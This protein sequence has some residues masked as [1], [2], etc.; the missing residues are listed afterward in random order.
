MSRF[1]RW[2]RRKLGLDETPSMSAAEP[3]TEQTEEMATEGDQT[4]NM[5]VPDTDEE[6]QTPLPIEEGSLDDQLPDPDTLGPGSD[7]KAFMAPG[8]SVGL[9][10]RALRRLFAIGNYNVRDGLDDY[11]H[12]YSQMKTLAEGAS[13][14]IRQWT[15]RAADALEED[16]EGTQQTQDSELEPTQE[17]AQTSPEP[18]EDESESG[19]EPIS[20]GAKRV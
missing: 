9:R 1:E 12:D 14:T 6:P 19:I 8:V 16:T 15:K 13:E 10:R 17:I 20:D 5:I 7:F 4:A 18:D 3:V 11:D 2:S